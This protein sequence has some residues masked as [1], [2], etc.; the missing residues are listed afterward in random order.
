MSI[1]DTCVFGQTAPPYVTSAFSTFALGYMSDRSG[2]R[3]PF[4]AVQSVAVIVGL[5]MTGFAH[6]NSV[7]LLDTFRCV[8]Q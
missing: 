2:L 7:C 3:A 4:I 5:S 8:V 6:S 1:T